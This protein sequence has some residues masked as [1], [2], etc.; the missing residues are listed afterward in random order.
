LIAPADDWQLA[1]AYDITPAPLPGRH[2]R[3][4]AMICGNYGRRARR[5]N[6]LSGC[7]QFGI[8][9]DV[10]DQHITEVQKTVDRDWQAM[11]Q[12]CGGTARDCIAVASAFNDEGFEYEVV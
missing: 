2:E 8:E 6:L 5:G 12:Q 10:A 9:H 1:P 3:D 7:L 11:I 4:L